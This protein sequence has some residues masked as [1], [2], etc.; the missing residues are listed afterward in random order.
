[1]ARVCAR[2][3]RVRS[4]PG[5]RSPLTPPIQSS[6]AVTGGRVLSDGARRREGAAQAGLGAAACGRWG[7]GSLSECHAL[8]IHDFFS[9]VSSQSGFAFIRI[10][11]QYG[12]C[13]R[14]GDAY[15]SFSLTDHR[16]LTTSVSFHLLCCR[17]IYEHCAGTMSIQY[18]TYILDTD[19]TKIDNVRMIGYVYESYG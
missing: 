12:R 4:A 6:G 18:C 10:T 14:G 7:R 16:A 2:L 3:A 13:G 5:P 17:I 9:K 19:T 15:F 1:M 8:R 11:C